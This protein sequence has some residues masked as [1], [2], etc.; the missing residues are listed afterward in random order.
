MKGGY[1][2]ANLAV[3]LLASVAGAQPTNFAKSLPE[4]RAQLEAHLNQP[5]FSG[6]LWGVK[7]AS[8]DTGRI[9][10]ES[11]ADRLMSPASNSKLYAGALALDRLGGD[12]RFATP[13]MATAKVGRNGIVHGDLIVAGRGDPSWKITNFWDNFAPFVAVLTNAGVR[14]ITGD[15]VADTIV[16]ESRSLALRTNTHAS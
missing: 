12:Y 1:F 13:I 2:L 5:R 9:I 10:Y 8:L 7:I 4:L 16:V 15:L 3:L 14:G 6:A 11:H